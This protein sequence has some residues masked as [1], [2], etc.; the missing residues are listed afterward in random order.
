[1][2]QGAR[3][4][5]VR[6][7]ILAGD[8]GTCVDGGIR[9]LCDQD[10]V[11]RTGLG[12]E[13]GAQPGEERRAHRSTGIVVG[14]VRPDLGRVNGCG[15]HIVAAERH[16]GIR[17]A[18]RGRQDVDVHVGRWESAACGIVEKGIQRM[19]ACRHARTVSQANG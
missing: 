12:S 6:N 18:W 4:T 14:Q 7:R 2:K 8:E 16:N 13:A 9:S 5:G 17:L 19:R 1:V 15:D 3:H 11:E 10:E